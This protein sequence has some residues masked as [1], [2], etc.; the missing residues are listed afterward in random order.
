MTVPSRLA[1]PFGTLAVVEDVPGAFATT[2]EQVVAARVSRSELPVTIALSGGDTA[3]QCYERLGMSETLPWEDIECFLGDERCV[4]PDHPDANQAMIRHALMGRLPAG[5][6]HPMDCER[7]RE[8]SDLL[9][10]VGSLDL[11]H[12]GLGPDGH[13]ASIFPGSHTAGLS[14]GRLVVRSFDPAGINKHG[15]LT[16]TFAA[17]DR[18]RLVVFTVSGEG[19][20][21]A[22]HRVLTG[23]DLPAARVRAEQVLWLCDPEALGEDLEKVK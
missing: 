14:D 20:H 17:L 1:P 3:R 12:L 23:E 2:V 10:K 22:L 5:A 16:L 15:R 9:E 21:E 19:K 11:V 4:P 18:A 8:Y 13:T 7:P 6:F